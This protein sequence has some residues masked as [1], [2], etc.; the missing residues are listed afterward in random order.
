MAN[1]S[2]FYLLTRNECEVLYGAKADAFAYDCTGTQTFV[3]VT[4]ADRK[5]AA[6][7][8]PILDGKHIYT[9]E[10]RIDITASIEWT[11]EPSEEPGEA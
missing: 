11:G 2:T 1:K 7:G 8:L 4:S 9:N 10:E 3:N 5:A 6:L